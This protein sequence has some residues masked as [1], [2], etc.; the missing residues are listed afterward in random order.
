MKAKKLIEVAMPIKEIS[1]E[2]VR[3]KYIHHGHISTLHIWWARRPLPICRASVFASLV[4]DP[5][6]VNCPPAFVEA[7]KSLIGS[8]P[9]YTPYKDIPYTAGEDVMEDNLRNRLLMFVAKFSPSTQEAMI[10]GNALSKDQLQAGCLSKSESK[11][12]EDTILLA[13]K[14]IWVSYNAGLNPG[15]TYEQLSSGFDLAIKGINRVEDELYSIPDRHIKTNTVLE[16]E[17]KLSDA[18]LAFLERMPV[19]F[20]PFAG[21]GAIPLEASRLG[22][23]SY[24][25]DINPVAH[26]IERAS[27]EYPQKYGKPITYSSSSFNAKYGELGHTMLEEKCLGFFNAEHI[28]IENRLAFDVEYYARTIL[29]QAKE[30]FGRIYPLHNGENPVAYYWARTVKCTN[31]SCGADVPMLKQFYLANNKRHKVYM[32]PVIHG[33]QIDFEI[34]QGNCSIPGWNNRGVVTCPCCGSVISIDDV[35]EQSKNNGLKLRLL[36]T[37]MDNGGKKYDIATNNDLPSI[38]IDP[39]TVSNASMQRNSGGGDTFSWGITKW[40]Q[41]FLDRQLYALKSLSKLIQDIPTKG[42]EYDIAVKTYL[43]LWFDRIAAY[44]TSF[45]RWIPQNEQLTS[46]FGRQAI[47]MISDFPELNIFAEST[48]G[49]INQLDWVIEYI[50]SESGNPFWTTLNNISSGDVNQFSDKSITSVVTDPPYYNAIAYADISDFFYIWLQKM[51]G[52]EY[53]SIFA[54]PQTPK[55]EECTALKHHHNN[56]EEEA[57]KH[58]E[59]KLLQIFKAIETQTSDIVSIMFAHQSTEAW[60]TLCNSILGANMNIEG[61]WAIDTERDTRMVANSGDALESSVTVACRPS[62]KSGFASFKNIKK[63]I[64]EKVAEEVKNLYSLGFRGA[65]LLTACF[66]KAVSVFG[67]YESV[68]KADGSDVTVAELLELARTSAYTALIRDFAGDDYTKFYI[69]WLEI[70]GMGDTDFDDATKFTRVGLNVN[71]GDIFAASI[72]IK[73]DNARIQHLA[74]FKERKIDSLRFDA[75]SRPLIDRV[76]R[77]MWLYSIGDRTDLLPF[78]AL[79]GQDINNDFWRV[80]VVLKELLPVSSEDYKQVSGLLQNAEELIRASKEAPR[81][82]K[83]ASLF[84]GL[85]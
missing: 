52:E 32:N 78:I 13:R 12:N 28:T 49:A 47:A 26:I 38:S 9:Q 30:E 17:K 46:L 4:D 81:P 8:N 42:D 76:H 57:K 11:D 48:S 41:L 27:L 54:T 19:V 22:C 15:Y 33:T 69:G 68:E 6:D 67:N 80:F 10:A 29:S 61:S 58:F 45:G 51:I 74:S 64:Q 31:P 16:A 20:D 40:T 71:I 18:I 44:N 1:A 25:N 73:D 63:A 56:S 59:N 60:T 36:A 82:A 24:G 3:D 21:G 35:K 50:N 77:A 37:I 55:T 53:P 83:E 79:Y 75:E 7:V 14:L 62:E 65:D 72:L 43:S 84:D 2:S 5:L 23:R 85:E 39:S 70:N 34:K 66:G